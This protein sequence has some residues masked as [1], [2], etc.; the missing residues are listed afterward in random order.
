MKTPEQYLSEH[1]YGS[2]TNFTISTV[3]HLIKEYHQQ[4]LFQPTDEAKEKVDCLIGYLEMWRDAKQY[5][6][7]LSLQTILPLAISGYNS[8]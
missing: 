4:S 3:A 6:S 1:G 7:E 8:S 2:G 5:P